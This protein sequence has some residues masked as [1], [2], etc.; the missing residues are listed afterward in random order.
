MSSYVKATNFATK[1]T[2]PT[3]DSGKIVKGTEIDSEF[4]AIA[5][6]ISSK[7]DTASPTFTGTPAAPTATAGANTTQ[8]AT[9]AFVTGAV[10]ASASSTETLTNK[11]LT[12][13]TINGGTITGITDLAIADGGTGASTAAD[14][15]TN[16]GLGSLATLS[17]VGTTE[18]TDL[19][20]TPAKL[21][22]KLTS[23]TA[24]ASTS[25]TSI[26]FTSVPSWVK[27]IT[28]MFSGV[29]T[30]G[31]S[32]MQAQIGDSGGI[33]TTG[34]ASYC[35]Y[36]G[37]N[38]SALSSV[39]TTGLLLDGTTP[40]ADWVRHG[41]FVLTNISGN[42]WVYSS[43]LGCDRGTG[44]YVSLT[45]GGSKTLSATLD[46]IRITTVNG[47]NTFDAGS[48]NILYE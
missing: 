13:P 32:L 44:F 27:R 46:R 41:S 33:E 37:T 20:V 30:N 29:S 11:T 28:V 26:D 31:N 3:G 2:L 16:L 48:I 12:S 21:S 19:A 5:S 6:A 24:V 7:A 25:G 38:N 34:Y 18:I 15:R 8:V 9:T 4:N 47:T 35:C 14:A 17:A 22:Q 45:G 10:T 23:G 40:T 43:T 1:D 39:S 36:A 42:T